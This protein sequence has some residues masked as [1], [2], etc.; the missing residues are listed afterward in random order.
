MAP[1]AKGSDDFVLS[2]HCGSGNKGTGV[3]EG[4]VRQMRQP[5]G[6]CLDKDGSLFVADYG[7]HCVYRFFGRLKSGK[8]LR[9]KVVAG[10]EG[11]MLGDYDPLKDIESTGPILPP[12]G[13]GRLLKRP[14]DVKMA[15][16]GNGV[17]VLD[18]ETNMVQHYSAG[19]AKSALIVGEKRASVNTPDGLKYPRVIQPME[20]GS[21]AVADAFSHRLLKCRVQGPGENLG[22]PDVLAG[23]PNST[24]DGP[25]YLAFPTG[26]V[27]L[28]DGSLVVADT[29]HHRLQKFPPGSGCGTAAV[30]IAG[31]KDC[32]AGSSLSELNMPTC[33][34]LD[35]RDGSILVTDRDN[36]RVLRFR[37]DSKAGDAGEL[38]VGQEHLS[39]PWGLCVDGQTGAVFVSDERRAVV[40]RF[41][42]RQQN[43]TGVADV[44]E[45]ETVVVEEVA[46]KG[47]GQAQ[48]TSAPESVSEKLAAGFAPTVSG[49]AMDLD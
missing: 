4:G 39:K 14:V 5:R 33:L 2:V 49:S 6:I 19:D 18:F 40:L 8:G 37:A 31:S 44:E 45:E 35:P 28:P 48:A 23:T 42:P 13:E 16:D 12:D 38:V 34:A 3:T 17:F 20:D 9:S 7:N 10:D 36:A 32:K 41:G 15:H 43:T 22:K 47:P 30:T 1:Q 25:E 46:S 24:H 29:N 11:N 21:I 26:F 27:F